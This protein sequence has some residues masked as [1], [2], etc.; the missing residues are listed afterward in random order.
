MKALTIAIAMCLLGVASPALAAAPDPQPTT[1]VGAG[2]KEGPAKLALA[3][4]VFK[5]LR[6]EESFHS[7]MDGMKQVMLKSMPTG[8]VLTDADKQL[9]TAAVARAGNA[10]W[11]EYRA[12]AVAI[13]ADTFTEEELAAIAAFYES[14]TGRNFIDKSRVELTPKLTGAM[15]DLTPK[16]MA[17]MGQ[18]Y[19]DHKNESQM[20]ALMCKVAD[21]M[22]D[23]AGK[24]PA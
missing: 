17:E 1:T 4:R 3:E 10:I 13:Y 7:R 22:A 24:E 11:P 5:A 19:C 16:M 15:T 12:R 20:G 23:P 14:P 18:E 6:V 9:M 21:T 8:G 2:A